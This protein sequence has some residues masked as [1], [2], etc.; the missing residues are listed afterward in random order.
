ML[1]LLEVAYG[2]RVLMYGVPRLVPGRAWASTVLAPLLRGPGVLL[3]R[4]PVTA[5]RSNI[6]VGPGAAPRPAGAARTE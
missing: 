1:Q 6:D 3:Y 5:C 4:S 2:G